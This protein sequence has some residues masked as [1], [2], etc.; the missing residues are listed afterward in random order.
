MLYFINLSFDGCKFFG[1]GAVS[2]ESK[3]LKGQCR[4]FLWF[5]LFLFLSEHFLPI[6]LF[7]GRIIRGPPD[8]FSP[9]SIHQIILFLSFNVWMVVMMATFNLR[10][11]IKTATKLF[12]CSLINSWSMPFLKVG[13]SVFRIFVKWNYNMFHYFKASIV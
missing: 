4:V 10:F 2:R 13:V 6:I 1:D 9:L 5:L 8:F 12:A 7:Q 11:L 3:L